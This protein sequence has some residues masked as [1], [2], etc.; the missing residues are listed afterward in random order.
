ML[1]PAARVP[2]IPRTVVGRVP[3]EQSLLAALGD[4]AGSFDEGAIRDKQI[5]AAEV[6]RYYRQCDRVYRRY[7]SRQGALHV[8]L[9]P[10]GTA[11]PVQ[12]GHTRQA[13]LFG[14]MVKKMGGLR[15]LEFG[16]GTGY[17]I[18]LLS[19]WYPELL[20]HG[21][22][23]SNDHISVANRLSEGSTNAHFLVGNYLQLDLPPD[24]FDAILAVETLC[25]SE[26]QA[27]ALRGA[28]R[29]LRPGG[30]MMVIDCF[31]AGPL[32]EVSEELARAALL[33]E[34]TAAVDNFAEI[35]HWTDLARSLGFEVE[36]VVDRSA[37]TTHDLAR[38]YRMARRFFKLPPF[39]RSL[40]R[41]VAPRALQNVICG[42]LMPYTVGQ[43][44][45]RYLSVTLAKPK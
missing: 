3:I 23:L 14:E 25:Q 4:I 19:Q 27:A 37:E 17:N 9:V 30:R 31:R 20:W 42:L 11:R 43:G 15:S 22:D 44:F 5:D 7:H 36:E 21:V 12:H 41:R 1:S 32:H 29:L 8:G 13:E 18:R 38:L 35:G 6:L 26:S 33:V 16:C 2:P 34:K 10:P 45:H 40:S 28:W 24:S 39:A